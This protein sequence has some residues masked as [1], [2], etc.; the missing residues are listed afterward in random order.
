MEHSE[1]VFTHKLSLVPL[2]DYLISGQWSEEEWD[3]GELK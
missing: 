1:K 3:S 2:D